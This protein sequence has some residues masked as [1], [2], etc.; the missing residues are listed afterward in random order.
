[1]TR[2]LVVEDD[3]ATSGLLKTVFG[4]EGFKTS[5]CAQPERV[6]EVARQDRPD[7]IFM[8]YHLAEVESLSILR[9]LKADAELKGIP[10]VMT[11]GL[12]RAAE[13]EEAGA[14]GFVLKPYRPAKLVA[15]IRAVLGA[16][17]PET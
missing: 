8:D 7:L 10:V 17:P 5:V 14:V 16:P 6:L 4:M 2:I 11:S 9:E 15:D 12:D 1:V 3:R 13:A